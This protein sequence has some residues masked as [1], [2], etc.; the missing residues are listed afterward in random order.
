M[1]P[2]WSGQL[3]N[4]AD[5]LRAWELAV[6][7][8]EEATRVPMPDEV[9]CSV[10]AMHAPRAIQSYLRVSDTDLLVNYQTMRRGIF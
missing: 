3:Q 7:R 4:F 6:Q 8:Y 2:K 1:K 9:R 10:V 5:E